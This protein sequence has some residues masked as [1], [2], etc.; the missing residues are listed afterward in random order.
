[1]K[2][3]NQNIY[4]SQTQLFFSDVFF[5]MRHMSEIIQG[6][7]L[8]TPFDDNLK[9]F[10]FK[11]TEKISMALYLAT[12][13]MS[14]MDSLKTSIRTLANNIIKDIIYLNHGQGGNKTFLKIKEDFIEL[15]SLLNIASI[16][17]LISIQ[18][19]NILIDELHKLNKEIENHKDNL[20][21]INDLKK[22]F[23]VVESRTRQVQ[24]EDAHK[25]HKRQENLPINA[26]PFSRYKESKDLDK[27]HTESSANNERREEIIKIIKDNGKVTIKDI[28]LKIKDCSEKTIQRELLKMV[29]LNLIK[30]EGERR[31]STYSTF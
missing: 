5:T 18:N 10:L 22:S 14:D 27:G 4:E 28:S 7:N 31:W 6:Q 16:S 29:S 12:A 13:H 20:N 8:N 19:I 15:N 30:K 21:S 9:L 2:N 26:F 11:K 24:E 3:K 1:M 23:F 25:G 17:G